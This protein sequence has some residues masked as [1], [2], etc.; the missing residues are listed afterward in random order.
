MFRS[1]LHKMRIQFISAL[2]LP[3]WIALAPYVLAGLLVIKTTAQR[4]QD[5]TS[6]HS[7]GA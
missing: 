5:A 7:F 1:T 3:G 2:K 6:F 4:V